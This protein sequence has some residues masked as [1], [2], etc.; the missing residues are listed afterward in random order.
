M[1]IRRR[2]TRPGGVRRAEAGKYSGGVGMVMAVSFERYGRLYYLDP[3][4]HRPSVGDRVLVPTDDGP[5]VAECVWAPAWVS[6]DIGGMPVL[7]G[8]AGPADLARDE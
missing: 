7:A 8:V 1:A 5:E 4:E 6:E 2:A 3:G